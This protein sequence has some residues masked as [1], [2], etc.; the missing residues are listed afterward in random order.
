MFPFFVAMTWTWSSDY[1]RSSGPNPID[2]PSYINLTVNNQMWR[3]VDEENFER[4]AHFDQILCKKW[5]KDE[6]NL[7]IPRWIFIIWK[8]EFSALAYFIT[9]SKIL[10]LLECL[11]SVLFLCFLN[12]CLGA[13]FTLFVENSKNL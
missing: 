2:K 3:E 4:S 6:S 12:F 9:F 1:S 13:N 10:K 8:I 7:I 11:K 5:I